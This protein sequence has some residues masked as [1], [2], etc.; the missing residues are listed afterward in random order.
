[1]SK[2]K[3]SKIIQEEINR[4]NEQIDLKIIKGLSYKREAQ[5]HKFLMSQLRQISRQTSYKA[6]PPSSR[7]FMK[8]LSYMGTLFL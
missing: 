2:Y 3:L 1:M 7:W 8:S 4:L 6:T 5:R